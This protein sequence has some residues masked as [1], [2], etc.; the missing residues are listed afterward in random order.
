MTNPARQDG[1]TAPEITK[2]LGW[3]GVAPFILCG[4]AAQSGERVLVLYGLVGGT[5]Y[6]AMILSFLGAVHWGLAMRDDR[7]YGWYIW[8][9]AP[10]LMG[11][12]TL[13][14]FDIQIRLMALIPL[15]TLAWAIDRIAAKQG[16]IPPWYMQLRTGLTIGAIAGLALMA[17]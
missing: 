6:A 7:H 11:W 5:S 15:F 8:S 10:A 1:E 17:I 3:G 13:L 9:I 2:I 16:L 4:A 12:A 14:V